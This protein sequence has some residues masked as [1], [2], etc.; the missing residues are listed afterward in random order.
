MPDATALP[1]RIVFDDIEVDIE[2]RRLLKAGR[3]VALEPKAFD[4]L[5]L[6][7]QH[8]GKALARDVLLDGVWGHRHVTPGVL[9]RVVVLLRRALGDDP[10]QERYIQ[11]VHGV[12]Y[13]LTL[14]RPGSAPQQD[15]LTSPAPPTPADAP[16]PAA[17]P[18]PPHRRNTDFV[19]TPPPPAVAR[20]WRWVD[21][22]VVLA[23]LT[24]ITLIWWRW[25]TAH[26]SEPTTAGTANATSVLAVL[27]LRALGSDPRGQA[28]ADGLSEELIGRLAHIKGLRVTSR[29]SSFQFRDPGISVGEIARRL[30]AS[31]VLEGSVRQ[32]G[33]RLRISLRLIEA[34]GDRLLWS[35]DFDRDLSDIFT[36]QDN[37][38][39]AVGSALQLQLDVGATPPT[40]AN[41]DPAL[42]RR[43]LL[44]RGTSAYD[45]ATTSS[46]SEQPFRQLVA[47]HPEYARAWGGLATALW[48]HSLR[49]EPGRDLLR[50]ES[51]RAAA[52]ALRLDPQQP[53]A[54]AVLAGQA[55]R[56]QRWNDCMILS[57]RTV[58][59][60]PAD[61]SWRG[62]H[63]SRLATMGYVN[64]ALH[65]IDTAQANDPLAPGL[66]FWRG[67]L[68]DT[69]GRHDEARRHLLLADPVLATTA[70]YFNAAWRNDAAEAQRIAESLPTETPWRASEIA[71]ARALA[72]PALWSDVTPLIERHERD[73]GDGDGR[74][75]YD[76]TRL[77]MPVRDYPRDIAGLD[78]VQRSGY[79]SYQWVFWQPESR[80]LRQHPAFQAYLRRSGLLA[81]WREHGW[82]DACHSDGGDGVICD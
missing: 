40:P 36:I 21:A 22:V 26:V 45:P 31:H 32:D 47:D 79:A 25:P 63:A 49:A 62:W 23:V 77:L 1:S 74:V 18:V 43:Y 38:A 30:H 10:S 73:I 37:I 57:R 19:A 52:I 72:D 5:L 6:M 82:P 28:F 29:T 16:E 48:L 60:N 35:Q 66:Q 78:G 27:P 69:L 70:L 41:E 9:N 53:D 55:C 2:G 4:V 13:R 61:A 54:H 7:L 17:A 67:R 56:E 75:P 8:P 51:E 65:E 42:Y 64:A 81:Y 39:R 24:A 59:L 76:F 12:G 33:D 58:Q 11:T 15:A 50:A 14:P 44:A 80:A 68:L 3:E 46:G 34:D 20:T 71:A